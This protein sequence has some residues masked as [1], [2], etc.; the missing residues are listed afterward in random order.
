MAEAW[1][2]GPLEGFQPVVMPA[3]FALVQ[4][5]EEIER[6]TAGLSSEQLWASPGGGAASIGY[7]LRHVAGSTDRLLT[8]AH[9]AQLS[10]EQIAALDAEKASPREE[11]TAARLTASAAQAIDRALT[12]LRAI[13]PGEMHAPRTVGRARVPVTLYVLLCHV[14]EHTTR[15]AAQIVTTAK[16]VRAPRP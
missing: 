12:E 15:H 6:A 14:A 1:L 13:D 9:G 7:H 3:A 8:Y 2:R 10:P 11:E 5:R 4:A 16:I